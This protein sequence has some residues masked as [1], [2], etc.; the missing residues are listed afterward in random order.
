[1]SKSK[2]II[3]SLLSL[4]LVA[5]LG[6]S[7][8]FIYSSP[9]DTTPASAYTDPYQPKGRRISDPADADMDV[10][11]GETVSYK[12][13]AGFLFE[14][15]LDVQIIDVTP[16]DGKYYSKLTLKKG[17]G[18]MSVDIKDT[19][20][21]SVDSWYETEGQARSL[22][23]AVK[24]DDIAA[25]QYADNSSLITVAV[26]EGVLYS[27]QSTR[28]AEFWDLVH[29]TFVSSFEFDVPD[30]TPVQVS[31]STSG[32]DIIYEQEEIVE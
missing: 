31:T 10:K 19:N 25:K 23:G 12:D 13:E 2:L 22:V 14:H 11:T 28:D 17:T 8:Y 32:D 1:M 26:D 3:T 5:G 18:Y 15:P 9:K 7:F 4:G 16:D 20:Y 27:I 24:L 30:A 6:I 29:D 21:S